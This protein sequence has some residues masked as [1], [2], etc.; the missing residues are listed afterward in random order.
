MRSRYLAFVPLF[1]FTILLGVMIFWDPPTRNVAETY[2]DS[3]AASGSIS[4]FQLFFGPLFERSVD[5]G[6]HLWYLLGRSELIVYGSLAFVGILMTALVI[7]SGK[8]YSKEELRIQSLL[9]DLTSEKERAQNLAKLKSEFLNQVSH[10]L[11]TPLAVIMGYVDCMLDGLYG[12]IDAKHEEILKAVSKQSV[13]L[14]EMI[15]RILTFSRLEA[16][17]SRVRIEQFPISR[18]L[19]SMRET[20]LFIAHQKGIVVEWELPEEDYVLRSDPERIKEILNNLIQNAIK[21]TSQGK[22]SVRI[23]YLAS[24]DAVVIEVADTGMGIP[25]ERLN[26]IFEPFVQV[27]KT[28]TINAK[29]GVGLGLSIVKKHVEQLRGSVD[30]QSELGQGTTFRIL[31]PRFHEDREPTKKPFR[32]LK[33]FSHPQ[34]AEKHPPSQA[35]SKMQP[36]FGP[37]PNRDARPLASSA[38]TH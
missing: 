36:E 15:D 3:R 2:F 20:Y 7:R 1:V 18:I 30:V 17:R 37:S 10:E 25:R 6:L 8:G 21:F 31:L 38:S 33:L 34:A 9:K 22:V 14:K 35:A 11:R 4:R 16:D 32:L 5:R 24:L 29:G 13:D 28:S 23:Q 12:Q 27:N 26:S 19:V